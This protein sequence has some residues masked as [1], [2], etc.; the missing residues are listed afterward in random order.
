MITINT[1]LFG[2]LAIPA[3]E[4]LFEYF[5]LP[6]GGKDVTFHLHIFED[7]LNG[8]TAKITGR[9]LENFQVLYDKARAY[10]AEQA[11]DSDV[12][13]FFRAGVEETDEDYL[14]GL[15]GVGSTE[16]ITK[17][18][19]LAALELRGS[20]IWQSDKGA[21]GCVLDFSLSE[22]YTDELLAVSFNEALEP[23]NIANE[24]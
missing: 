23:V 16:D 18:M 11:D 3:E 24:S 8:D 21:V 15:F 5:T 7:F 1:P 20:H 14:L 6:L 17:E 9:F 2:E 4:G 22:E 12:D 19:Y 10:I 13:Y